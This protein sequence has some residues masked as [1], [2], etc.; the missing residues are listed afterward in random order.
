LNFTLHTLI[1]TFAL[2]SELQYL[3]LNWEDAES[4]APLFLDLKSPRERN[5]KV[6]TAMYLNFHLNWR[7]NTKR[8][9]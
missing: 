6:N 2:G 1:H 7:L 4:L 9:L 5:R 3:G 8:Q